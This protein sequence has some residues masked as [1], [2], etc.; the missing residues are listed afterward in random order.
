MPPPAHRQSQ[1]SLSQPATAFPI[2]AARQQTPPGV[3][4]YA[5]QTSSVVQPPLG[6]E[7]G[8]PG[9]PISA[10]QRQYSPINMSGPPQ[11]SA[12]TQF[13]SMSLDQP[14]IGTSPPAHIVPS[15]FSADPPPLR[16]VFGESLRALFDRDG[17]AVPMIVYQCIQAIDLYGLETEGIYRLSGTNSHVQQIRAMFDN[18]EDSEMFLLAPTGLMC[19]RFFKS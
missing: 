9:P 18:G 19:T 13:A 4:G 14:Q 10:M 8:P 16:P 3:Q 12:P 5:P 1:P 11:L 7:F 15:S 2:Q 6:N 17:S